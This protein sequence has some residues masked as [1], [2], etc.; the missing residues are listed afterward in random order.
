MRL[1][2]TFRIPRF[3]LSGYQSDLKKALADAITKAAIAWLHATTTKIPVWSGASLGTFR[4]LASQVGFQVDISVAR[5]AP[6]RINLGLQNSTGKL[7]VSEGGNGRVSFT[8]GTTLAHLV[9]NEFNNANAVPDPTLFSK[10][11]NPGPYNFQGAGEA[12]A[13][14]SIEDVRLPDPTKRITITTLRV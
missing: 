4:Q 14:A 11:K 10:L 8:Y 12:A 7:D 5:N 2:A 13:R 3:D 6:E 1:S 9:Y